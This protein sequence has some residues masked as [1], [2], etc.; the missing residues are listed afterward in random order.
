MSQ[1][2]Y[3]IF[4]LTFIKISSNR[5]HCD[6]HVGSRSRLFFYSSSSFFSSNMTFLW[7]VYEQPKVSV[8]L[9]SQ[10]A[11]KVK[12]W[13]RGKGIA[14]DLGWHC[15]L[16]S[17]L[18]FSLRLDLKF[19]LGLRWFRV[20]LGLAR[21]QVWRWRAGWGLII[22]RYDVRPRTDD[23]SYNKWT[24]QIDIQQKHTVNTNTRCVLTLMCSTYVLWMFIW[25]IQLSFFY[26]IK[27]ICNYLY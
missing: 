2:M 21:R 7:L 20:G 5:F 9:L 8:V 11:L 18:W 16:P 23:D 22:R 3:N 1:P 26:V 10:I 14:S 25:H 12:W 24:P 19:R 17:R 15:I 13:H 27:G 4:Y 6:E